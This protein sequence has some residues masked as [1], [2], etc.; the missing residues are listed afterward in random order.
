MDQKPDE[1]KP[2]LP[3][4][5]QCM[6]L[7][8]QGPD[9]HKHR[10]EP[11]MA[12]KTKNESVGIRAQVPALDSYLTRIGAEELNFRRFMV[13]T[14]MKGGNYYWEKTLVQINVDGTLTCSREEH[15]P[16]DDERKK[17][18]AELLN[19]EFPRSVGASLR[20]AQAQAERV[21]GTVYLFSRRSDKSISMLQ[22]RWMKESGEKVYV[23]WTLWSDGVWRKMEPEGDLPFWKPYQ[24]FGRKGSPPGLKMIHEGAKP[25]QFVDGL[26][27]DPSRKKELAAHPWGRELALYEHWGMIGGA[28]APHRSDYSE[29]RAEM[30]TEVVYV[31]D[32]D[33]PGEKALEHVSRCYGEALQAVKFGDNFKTSWDMADPMPE[34]LFK[35]GRYVGSRLQDF[36]EPSTWACEKVPVPGS[37]PKKTVFKMREAFLEEW[38]HVI[39]PEVYLHR[40][41]P[42]IRYKDKEFNNKVRPYSDAPKTHEVLQKHGVSKVDAMRYD[43][44]RPPGIYEDESGR[45]VNTHMPSSILPERGDPAPFLEYMAHLIPDEGDRHEIFKWCATLIARP[46]IKMNY[47]MLLISETQGVG[48]STLGEKILTPLIGKL[49]ASAPSENAVVDHE[50]NGWQAHKRLI[51]I[52]EIK[53]SDS[54]KAY[55]KLK[56]VITEEYTMIHLKGLDIYSMENYL[57]VYACSNSYKA[58]KLDRD[59]RRWYFPRVTEDKPP[60]DMFV[61]LNDWLKNKGG[62][63]IIRWWAEEFIRE[64]GPVMAGAVAPW[65]TMKGEVIK[66]GYSDGQ[67]LVITTLERVKSILASEQPED[68][69]KREEWTAKHMLVDGHVLI[70]DQSLRALIKFK[71]HDDRPTEKLEKLGTIRK[72]A[73][74]EGWHLG[75]A[76]VSTGMATWGVEAWH[77]RVISNDATVAATSPGELGG[78]NSEHQMMPLNLDFMKTL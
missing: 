59:D 71:I 56:S 43:P 37:K 8:R 45:Y 62:L 3:R 78:K 69:R 14:Y 4:G 63:N 6:V 30:P 73:K 19:F 51:V 18:A 65:S 21:G 26:C 16:T 11:P 44:G 57:H 9:N 39:H 58:L 41:W 52:H 27:N 20:A 55:D 1:V 70:T 33:F 32:N 77:A 25:A 2:Y 15:N 48:K 5:F 42:W 36:M 60:R 24:S 17:I 7:G 50:F 22:H 12:K 29:L 49:N 13:K 67:N 38:V 31:C 53:G 61:V 10:G 74:Q 66:E 72:L 34:L 35:D 68:V 54:R 46:D 40:K 76:Q 75:I 28:L 47:G 64:H 23:P